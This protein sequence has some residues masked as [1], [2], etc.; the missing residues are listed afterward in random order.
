MDMAALLEDMLPTTPQSPDPEQSSSLDEAPDPHESRRVLK[1]R[2]KRKLDPELSDPSKFARPPSKDGDG[3][4]DPEPPMPHLLLSPGRVVERFENLGAA[5]GDRGKGPADEAG[6]S[7]IAVPAFPCPTLRLQMRPSKKASMSGGSSADNVQKPVKLE[8]TLSVY[9]P[10]SPPAE[11]DPET[12]FEQSELPALASPRKTCTLQKQQALAVQRTPPLSLVVLTVD[13]E[14]EVGPAQQLCSLDA[15]Q[16]FG[17]L[18]L[19]QFTMSD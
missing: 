16:L 15:V 7:A 2:F 4:E 1:K 14:F 12:L 9:V 3:D 6:S 17:D 18:D 5:G 10:F 19:S 13:R 8:H 11:V